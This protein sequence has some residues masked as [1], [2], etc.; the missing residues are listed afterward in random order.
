[1]ELPTDF[2]G[3]AQFPL[4]ASGCTVHQGIQLGHNPLSV[5][6]GMPLKNLGQPVGQV[7][8]QAAARALVKLE[9]E[10]QLV[11]AGGFEGETD[12]I[13]PFIVV[14]EKG[15]KKMD[16]ALRWKEGIEFI[17]AEDGFETIRIAAHGQLALQG[18]E[19]GCF[20]WSAGRSCPGLIALNV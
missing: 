12:I 2:R 17:L 19:F 10:K 11:V 15:L 8:G 4:A 5:D 7:A 9:M 13:G 20:R 6:D 1:M 14:P 16:G 18:S 3:S